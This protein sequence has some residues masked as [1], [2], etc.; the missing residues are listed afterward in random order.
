[1]A[2]IAINIAYAEA[3]EAIEQLKGWCSPA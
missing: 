1:M 3:R 2:R